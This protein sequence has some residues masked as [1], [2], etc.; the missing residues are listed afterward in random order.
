[1]KILDDLKKIKELDKQDMLGIEERFVDQLITAQGIVKSA[2]YKNL[3]NKSFKGIAILG[4]GGSGVSGDI[5]KN[6][7]IDSCEVPVEVIKDYELPAFIRE[8][9]LVVAISYS[10]NTEETLS[11]IGE[12]FKR[13]CEIMCI[14]SGGKLME[15]ASEKNKCLVKVPG[16]LQ[17]RGASG[18]LLFSTL[19]SLNEIGAISISKSD[20][21]ESLELLKQK[22]LLYKRESGQSDNPA[23]QLALALEGCMAVVYGVSGFLSAIAYRWKCEINENSKCP[24]F[25]SEFPEL[26]HNETV[27]W[28]NL[29]EITKKFALIVFKDSSASERIKVRIDTTSELIR[30]NLGKIIEIPVEGRS[31]LARALST[32]YLGDISSV[33]LAFLYNTDPTPVDRIS[34][35]KTELAKLDK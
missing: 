13:N 5:I 27:G 28:E 17:P 29:S 23:K 21:D 30:K 26:N 34:V 14:S 3:K 2:D 10:G 8:G 25:S 12:A 11:A 31:K 20:I 19:L 24:S 9:W 33:Y 15:I 32:M 18:Y 16:G 7:V 4:M 1:M 6:L 35:L 22:V